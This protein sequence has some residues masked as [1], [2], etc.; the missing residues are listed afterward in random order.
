MPHYVFALPD[1]SVAFKLADML[2]YWRANRGPISEAELAE[3]LRAVG[4]RP[5]NPARVDPGTAGNVHRRPAEGQSRTRRR[6]GG[7]AGNIIVG[8]V[9][10]ADQ[11][12]C[13]E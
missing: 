8:I 11:P 13:A 4:F 3:R 9:E 2:A 5:F 7:D 1:G 12:A 10:A 6:S